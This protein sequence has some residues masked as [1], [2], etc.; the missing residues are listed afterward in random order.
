MKTIQFAFILTLLI[1]SSLL[2]QPVVS[3]S[4]IVNSAGWRN[5]AQPVSGIAQGSIFTIQGSG[6][7]PAQM[8]QASAI[9]LTTNLGGSSVSVT[10]GGKSVD[11]LILM[12]VSFQINA[13]LPSSTPA[14]SGTITVSYGGQTSTAQPI[15][16]VPSLFGIYTFNSAGFGQAI[17]T[18]TDYKP[19]TI[20]HTFNP[21][22]WV[23]LWGT[24]LGPISGSDAIAPPIGDIS[25]APAVHVGSTTV[26]PQYWGR[27][28]FP[29][30]DQVNFQVPAGVQGCYV[31]VAVETPTGVSNV[32]TIA[33]S[34]SGQTCSDSILG[35]DL[36]NKLAA[37]G[38]VDFGY[39]RLESWFSKS[40]FYSPTGESDFAYASFSEFT[41]QT[42][43]SAAYGVSQGYCIGGNGGG[44]LGYGD[45]SPSQLDAGTALTLVGQGT[46]S[47]AN[48]Y[49]PYYWF[50]AG[51]AAKFLWS[52]LRYTVSGAGGKNVGAFTSTD[53][54]SIGVVAFSSGVT[55]GQ[56]VPRSGDL[57]V[58]WTGADPTLQ[59][60]QVTLQAISANSSETVFGFV[61]CTVPASATS[62]TIPGW[63]LSLLPPSGTIQVGATAFPLGF[64]L[65]GQYNNP[66]TFQASGLD[67]GLF[68]D[69]FYSGVGVTFQ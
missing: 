49:G 29:G 53:T 50:N 16:V 26:V 9:P 45:M 37:G 39:I 11:A 28:G 62:F 41:P 38:K 43:G 2:A 68:T 17:A 34:S 22:D 60:G 25:S 30:L 48:A 27:S 56:T 66:T 3:P 6:I 47:M 42:A 61:M 63:L 19:N 54:T 8:V 1:A 10:V 52:D 57:T 32:A 21:G 33:V 58:R 44:T 31:P 46:V 4:G 15:Q 65:V 7:G 18:N 23:I 40:A 59:N 69:I 67:R 5:Q 36:V 51:T 14:G 55:P 13:I 64:L 20:I 35:Q 12:A 24:G